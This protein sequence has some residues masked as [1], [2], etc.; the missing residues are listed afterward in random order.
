M[1]NFIK[2]DLLLFWRN[3]R[4]TA[5]V[6]LLPII[7]VIVLNYA[8]SS[9]FSTG[10]S[11][12]DLKLA[13]VNKDDEVA[14]I[15]QFGDE[16]TD[17][18]LEE[19]SIST[20]VTLIYEFL[21]NRE[22]S[23]WLTVYELDEPEALEQLEQGEIDAI[24]TIP[25]DYTYRMLRELEL[26]ED[27]AIAL[28]FTVKEHSMDVSVISDVIHEFFDQI[29]FQLVFHHPADEPPVSGPIPEGG[30]EMMERADT[31]TMAQYFTIAMGALFALFIASTVAEKTGAEKREQVVNR[32]LIANSR[33]IF[34]LM[35]KVFSTFC[36]VWLQMM[37]VI[38]VSH[39]LLQ[40][41][42]G[43]TSTFWY[44]MLLMVTTFAM[45]MAGLSAFFTSIMLRMKSIDAANGLFMLFTMGFGLL[46]GNFVPIYFFPVWMQELGEWTPNGLTLAV[47]TEWIQYE[48]FSALLAPALALGLVSV[49]FLLVGAFL[50]P[51]RGEV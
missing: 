25:H 30:R 33:P 2:K 15:R 9:M 26:G 32:I 31:F 27:S 29:H 45:A 49:L 34:Y 24:L 21:H 19:A 3:R 13:M 16:A 20:P 11:P 44:G 46:G 1:L 36:L 42:E 41:F 28:P 23:E 10:S 35:G 50:Y 7:L 40:V 38:L 5:T 12:L 37:F 47:L 39:L 51:R 18:R 17:W 6:V 14:G 22:L 43:K 8:F 4:E 48:R